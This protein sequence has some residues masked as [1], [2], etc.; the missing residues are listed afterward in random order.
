MKLVKESLYEK[1]KKDSDPIK[2]MNIGFKLYRCGGCGVPTDKN[3]QP[4]EGEKFDDAVKA[5]ENGVEP[6]DLTI[7]PRCEHDI[8]HQ[9]L[10]W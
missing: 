2:D 5:I 10:D 6:K 8:Y 3:G 7:C 9:R 1:F 4:L